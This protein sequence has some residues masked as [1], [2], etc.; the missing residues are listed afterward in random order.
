MREIEHN[1]RSANIIGIDLGNTETRVARFN[2]AG[3]PEI[4]N[5]YEG[6]P[7]T[8]S[9]VLIESDGV[10]TSGKEAKKL[11]GLGCDNVFSEFRREM[12]GSQTWQVNG[13]MIT[14]ED[15]SGYLLK[16]V[17]SDYVQQ[18][19]QPTAV[20]LTWP[21]RFSLEQRNATK[22]AVKSAGINKVSFVEEPIAIALFYAAEMACEGKYLIYDF[23]GGAFEATLVQASRNNFSILRQDGIENFS[24]KEFDAAILKIVSAKFSTLTG[25]AF[26]AV[27]CNF[28]RLSVESIRGTFTPKD[29]ALIK[30]KLARGKSVEF[31]I[32]RE[33]LERKIHE[34]KNSKQA[35]EL[36]KILVEEKLQTMH[37]IGVE[38]VETKSL[39]VAIKAACFSLT[40][41]SKTSVRVVSASF[42][43]V[44]IEILREEFE[45]ETAYLISQIEATSLYTLQSSGIP[46]QQAHNEISGILMAGELSR[47]PSIKN[48]VE[49]LYGK[50][51]ISSNPEQAIAMGAAIYAARKMDLKTLNNLQRKAVEDVDAVFMS[52][53]YFGLIYTN[54][55]TGES[56]NITIVKRGEILPIRRTF[57]IKSDSSGY[58]P[59]MNLTQS[60][61][62]ETNP[63]FVTTI[64]KGE[65][66]RSSADAEMNLVFNFSK[67][68]SLAISMIDLG[69]GRST[70][71][72]LHLGSHER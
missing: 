54:W 56:T 51:P 3:K 70:K 58:L 52:P 8:P 36:L 35:E 55:I 57:K 60:A 62:E 63:E 20:A 23:G 12:G 68:G 13:R 38:S 66:Q 45:S 64:W 4:T 47:L 31:S 25:S 37:S 26:D 39:E 11:V 42:G 28:D 44:A 5:N 46:A 61:I 65:L 9:V 32:L 22:T 43:P 67:S 41:R 59:S 24:T 72:E 7:Y 6:Y 17:M 19:G 1:D 69:T 34:T 33:E 50:R 15:L 18:F 48:S 30:L 27:D 71:V 10:V 49:K 2:E 21:Y 53:D 14:P 29:S 16:Q 40:P